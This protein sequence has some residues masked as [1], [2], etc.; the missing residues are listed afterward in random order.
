MSYFYNQSRGYAQ[1]APV[2]G[3]SNYEL[4]ST[5]LPNKLVLVAAENESALSRV[6]V[7]FR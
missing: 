6:S 1:L 2:G 4:K 7:I 3:I 5:T